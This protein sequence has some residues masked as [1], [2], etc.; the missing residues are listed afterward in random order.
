[1]QWF[2]TLIDSRGTLRVCQ[3]TPVKNYGTKILLRKYLMRHFHIT[4]PNSALPIN[5]CLTT[6]PDHV[7]WISADFSLKFANQREFTQAWNWQDVYFV[8]FSYLD[9]LGYDKKSI[10]VDFWD[11]LFL[12]GFYASIFGTYGYPLSFP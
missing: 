11:F 9:A 7:A 2:S 6:W 3:S 5:L 10:L 4:L 12:F 1:M 8:Y